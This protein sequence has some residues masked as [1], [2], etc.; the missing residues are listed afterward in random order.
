MAKTADRFQVKVGSGNESLN[1]QMTVTQARR[2]G[3]R[4]MPADLRRAG[5][6]AVV[7]KAEAVIHRRVWL[8]VS[9]A[10]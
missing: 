1:E 7:C 9:Y 4:N 8:R 2:Y 6:K 10:K 5:F 3:D